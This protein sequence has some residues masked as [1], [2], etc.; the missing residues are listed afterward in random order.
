MRLIHGALLLPSGR[1]RVFLDDGRTEIAFAR[2]VLT[3]LVIGVFFLLG[4]LAWRRYR[5]AGL[6]TGLVVGVMLGASL[7]VTTRPRIDGPS[8]LSIL[9]GQ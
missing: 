9:R 7:Y 8:H 1:C 4:L 5:W 3:V 6:A 2:R